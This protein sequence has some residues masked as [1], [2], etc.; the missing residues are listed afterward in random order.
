MSNP[1]TPLRLSDINLDRLNK[2]LVQVYQQLTGLQERIEA[3]HAEVNNKPSTS[4]PG[5]PG[6]ANGSAAIIQGPVPGGPSP[7]PPW[8][9]HHSL[10]V[11]EGSTPVKQIVGTDGQI[12]IACSNGDPAFANITGDGSIAVP[13]LIAI[14]NACNSITIGVNGSFSTWIA[15]VSALLGISGP[16]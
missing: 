16:S 6:I 11:G 8:L 15:T 9:T 7:L 13:G 3:L 1:V 12:P 10:F 2:V 4:K 14:Q 5:Y